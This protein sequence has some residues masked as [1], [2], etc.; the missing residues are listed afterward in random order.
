[1]KIVIPLYRKRVAP[2]FGKVSTV[3]LVEV[4]KDSVLH[5]SRYDVG[6]MNAMETARK[7]LNL[8]VDTLICGGIEAYF[9][10]WL[11]RKGITVVDNQKGEAREALKKFLESKPTV[12]N[13]KP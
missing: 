2:H 4:R 7:L 11:I 3:L 6:G 10:D 12:G 5:E 9:K 13:R 1:M 8:E